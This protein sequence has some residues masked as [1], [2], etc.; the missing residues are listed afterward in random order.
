MKKEYLECGKI[1]TAHG[2]RGALRVQSLCDSA[3]VLAGLT[4]V[5]LR[6][7]SG[8]YTPCRVLAAS[9]SGDMALLTLE[10]YS[11]RD[12]ALALRGRMLYAK[13]E[14]IPVPEGGA[15]IADMLDLPVLDAESGRLYGHL[16][17]VQ[18]SP[19]SDLYEIRTPSGKTV[20]LP[21]VPAFLDRIDIEAGI[22]IRPIPGFFDEEEREDD[23]AL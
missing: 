12:A 16:T 18:P 3:A 23:H 9:P 5:Y 14:D 11:D 21:A 20:L 10:G 2:I 4:T 17:D 8:A 6:E 13:R 19:A 22:Y 15:L 1:T 7:K